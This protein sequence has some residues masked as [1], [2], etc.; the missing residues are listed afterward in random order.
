MGLV[1][2]N[3]R[4][5]FVNRIDEYIVFEGLKREQIKKIVRIQAKRVAERLAAK[6]VSLD[7]SESAVDYLVEKGYD[8]VYGAR[9]VKRAVQR[10]LETSLAKGFLKGDFGE[11]DTVVV[12]APGGAKAT[13]LN[14]TRRGS[15][16][17]KPVV[18]DSLDLDVTL[19]SVDP[20]EDGTPSKGS[21]KHGVA[22]E[23]VW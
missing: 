21:G 8:P 15:G 19:N 18:E 5:E 17:A 9:P 20:S 14:L 4:P 1:R 13:H 22:G 12:D 23:A 11:D 6:K 7:L 3:F 10:E 2:A 16:P